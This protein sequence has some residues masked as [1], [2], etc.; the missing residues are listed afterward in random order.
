MEA[1]QEGTRFAATYGATDNDPQIKR[2]E[3]SSCGVIS[4]EGNCTY[5]P[6][7]T[8]ANTNPLNQIR[9]IWARMR[10]VRNEISD[11]T[12]PS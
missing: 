11:T 2:V 5:H 7:M 8:R 4:K 9:W 1:L 12:A 10:P 6:L 3:A